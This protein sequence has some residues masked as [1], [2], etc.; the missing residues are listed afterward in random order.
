MKISSKLYIKS[1]ITLI[2]STSIPGFAITTY[3]VKS[4]DSLWRI[5]NKHAI[6]GIPNKDMVEAIKGINSKENPS[7]NDDVVNIKQKLLI[8][9]TRAEIDD[10]LK[11]YTLRHTQYLTQNQAQTSVPVAA[12][13]V[14]IETA[15]P[16]NTSSL[17]VS[18][19]DPTASSVATPGAVLSHDQLAEATKNN[20][21]GVSPV[22]VDEDTMVPSKMADINTEV[23]PDNSKWF[24]LL[25]IALITLFVWFRRYKRKS[26]HQKPDTHNFKDQFYAKQTDVPLESHGKQDK[27][28]EVVQK[29]V[30]QEKASHKKKS[31]DELGQLL[32]KADKLI[33]AHDIAQ[34]KSILQ[35]ALNSDPKNLSIRLKILAVYG[36]DGDEISFNSERDYLAS[37]LLPYDDS[38]W[39]EIKALY[40]KYFRID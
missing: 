20:S 26:Q 2:S 36:A 5:A 1:L 28:P 10:G 30:V 24:M 11:L 17:P 6:T 12:A 16:I 39:Q 7:I 33:E 3:T 4:G 35:E 34:A 25:F 29:E 32:H 13:T 38:R 22:N 15:A 40:H 27:R 9:S 37:N 18:T 19:Q 21:G 8:P 23:K 14:P 31:K